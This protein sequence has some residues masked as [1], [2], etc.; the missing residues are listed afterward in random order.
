M[1]VPENMTTDDLTGQ[2]VLVSS[3]Y[4]MQGRGRRPSIAG[5]DVM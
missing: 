1:A 2:F 5:F 3:R 4:Y